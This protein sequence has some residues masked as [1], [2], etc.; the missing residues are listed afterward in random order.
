M[1]HIRDFEKDNHNN[2]KMQGAFNKYG[3][4]IFSFKVVEIID[5]KEDLRDREIFWAN[6]FNVFDIDEG[7]N[8]CPITSCNTQYTKAFAE[9]VTGTKNGNSKLKNKDVIKICKLLNEKKLSNA[10]IGEIFGVTY[11]AIRSIAIGRTWGQL[12]KGYLDIA[13]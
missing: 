6:R 4:E 3:K 5:N 7:F 10:K 12:S 11:S 8:L 1:E 13:S 9:L 2:K